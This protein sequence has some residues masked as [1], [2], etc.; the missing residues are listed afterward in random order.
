MSYTDLVEQRIKLLLK[1]SEGK[2][3]ESDLKELENLAVL[4]CEAVSSVTSEE[5]KRFLKWAEKMITTLESNLVKRTTGDPI[6]IV[7]LSN[8]EKC[9]SF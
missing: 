4:M 5:D 9:F 7:L 8:S 2:V 1:K 6:D 3:T